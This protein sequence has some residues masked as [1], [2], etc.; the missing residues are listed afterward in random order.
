[1]NRHCRVSSDRRRACARVSYFTICALALLLLPPAGA[2]ERQVLHNH[3]PAAVARSAPTGSLLADT[4]LDLAIGLPWRNAAALTNLLRDLY[5][6]ASQQYHHFLTPEEF[7]QRFGP[8]Q[9]DYESVSAF[10]RA[11]GLTVRATHPNRMLL[12]VR[13]SAGNIEEALHVNL[14]SYKHPTENR[15]FFAPDAAPSV[16][17]AVQYGG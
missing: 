17:L 7:A 8:S 6:P 2:A 5:D 9:A 4:R 11:H 15:N 13:G 3:V 16:E 14:R 1:M 10:A 12:D